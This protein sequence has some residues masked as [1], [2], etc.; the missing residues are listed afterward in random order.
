MAGRAALGA[1]RPATGTA[2]RTATTERTAGERRPPR[3]AGGAEGAGVTTP[4]A[5]LGSFGDDM[6]QLI[7]EKLTPM[8]G[9]DERIAKCAVCKQAFVARGDERHCS[10]IACQMNKRY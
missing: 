7:L 4:S 6:D 2:T 3:A 10:L 1:A 9:T 5:P 8:L